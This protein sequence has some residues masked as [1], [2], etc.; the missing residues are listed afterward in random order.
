MVPVL[1]Q[2]FVQEMNWLTHGQFM[3]ALA[4]GQMTPGPVL[5]TVTFVGYKVAGFLGACVA[6]FAIFLASSFH[7]TTWFPK[8]TRW[9]SRQAWVPQFV[10]GALAAVIGTLIVTS[11]RLLSVSGEKQVLMTMVGVLILLKWKIPS[12]LVILSGGVLGFLLL[13][14]T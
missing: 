12:W 6:T 9:L 3:D 1:E 4:F 8:V 7:M 11:Y 5:I 13:R 14:P 2:G 10:L